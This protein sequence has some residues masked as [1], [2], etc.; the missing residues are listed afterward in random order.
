MS[1]HVIIHDALW[2]NNTLKLTWD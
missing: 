1:N 2:N